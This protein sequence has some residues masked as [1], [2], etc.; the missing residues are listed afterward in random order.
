MYLSYLIKNR[1]KAPVFS[2]LFCKKVA[3]RIVHFYGLMRLELSRIKLTK[4]GSVIGDLS[5][6]SN[7]CHLNGKRSH[8]TLGNNVF[9]GNAT[10]NLHGNITVGDNTVI[11][12]GA[13][14]ITASHDVD[15]ENWTQFAKETQIGK[16]VWIAT[17]ATILP[18]VSIADY[19][20]IGA[21]AV[22]SKSVNKGEIVA[23][24]PAKVIRKRNIADFTYS[25][26]R[27]IAPFDAWLN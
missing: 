23:G 27:F 3:K 26:V 15:S 22:V 6:V 20:V 16:F 9:I 2:L 18:G 25:P 12:D 17:G 8:L 1:N 11:N 14:I 24:N 10:L 13:N 4:A 19:A 5:I 21:G 7:R